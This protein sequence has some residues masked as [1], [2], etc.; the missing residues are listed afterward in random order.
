L[1][2]LGRDAVSK[3]M[4]ASGFLARLSGGVY[5]NDTPGGA[6][7]EFGHHNPDVTPVLLKV[8][9]IPG[10]N[11]MASSAP[12]NYVASHPLDVDSISAP[13]LRAPGT[14]NTN[15]LNRSA[16]PVGVVK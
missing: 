14:V 1:G 15:V 3:D 10:R 12:R 11:A 6:I 2:V 13:S 4:R 9:Y 16:R 8:E 7:A 5:V